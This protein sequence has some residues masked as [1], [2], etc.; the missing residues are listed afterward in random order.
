MSLQCDTD[1]VAGV[2][3][4]G[5]R[6]PRLCLIAEC[7]ADSGGGIGKDAA[8][9]ER[10]EAAPNETVTSRRAIAKGAAAGGLAT[11]FAAV[12]AGRVLADD[13][14]DT[15]PDL[16]D[17]PDTSPDDDDSPDTTP[18]DDDSPDTSPDLD[19]SPD[20][21]PGRPDEFDTTPDDGETTNDNKLKSSRKSGRG[22][23]R[24]RKNGRG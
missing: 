2:V 8:M 1:A 15:T 7:A 20:T 23:G 13:S 11:L 17:S 3:P 14:P 10:L 9:D 24:S 6:R 19:D 16:D 18:D 22:R 5:E 21:T 4:S 12:A